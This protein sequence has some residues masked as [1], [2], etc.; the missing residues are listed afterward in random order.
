MGC[1]CVL[2]FHGLQFFPKSE[3][4][5]ARSDIHT[6]LRPLGSPSKDAPPFGDRR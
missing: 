5:N 1:L 3:G 6:L 2:D 4:L